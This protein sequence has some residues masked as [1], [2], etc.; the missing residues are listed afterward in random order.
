VKSR[1]PGALAGAPALVTAAIAPAAAGDRLEWTG[2]DLS[3]STASADL[4]RIAG[5][6]PQRGVYVSLWLGY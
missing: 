1:I 4:G 2:G 5:R 3:L 6:P